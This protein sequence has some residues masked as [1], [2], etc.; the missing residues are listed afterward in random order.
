[1][2][3]RLIVGNN[4]AGYPAMRVV[5]ENHRRYTEVYNKGATAV[6]TVTDYD[7]QRKN[8][9]P[10]TEIRI[11]ILDPA[12]K[13]GSIRSRTHSI[14]LNPEERRALIQVLTEMEKSEPNIRA[15]IVI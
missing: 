2:S 4:S 10:W 12:D 15:E 3:R 14:T 6:L 1:M 5:D 8:P 7:G 9:D 11:E 13:R